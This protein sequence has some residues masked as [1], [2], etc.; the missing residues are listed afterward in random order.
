MGDYWTDNGIDKPR[1][2]I[3]CAACRHGK[4]ILCG[5]RHWDAV[6]RAQAKAIQGHD[7]WAGKWNRAEQ[8]FINQ[9]GEFLTREEA[10]Q[11]VKANGQYFN[12]DRNGG[13]RG[14]FSEGLY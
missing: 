7:G 13:D 9:F 14:L 2:I 12:A 1:Q 8:G 6:M 4:L 3:V 5:A 11:V 10:M